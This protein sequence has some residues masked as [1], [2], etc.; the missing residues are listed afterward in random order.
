MTMARQEREQFADMLEGLAPHQWEAETLCERWRVRDVAAHVISYDELG[1]VGLVQ[2]FAKG[3]FLVNRVNAV[4]VGDFADRTPLEIVEL[5]RRHAEPSGLTA[6][7]GGLIAL[8]D[9]MIHQQDIRRALGFPRT[10]ATDRLLAALNFAR[11]APT[12]RGAWRARGVRLVATDLDWAA[13]RGPEVRGPGEALLMAMAARPAALAD[14]E[15]P[16]KAKLA[17]HIGG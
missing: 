16:G 4:G 10:I 13:G 8:T 6:G 11:T 15:G 14:L 17:G 12:I 7:F 5:M 2:R 9:G 3:L 1:P